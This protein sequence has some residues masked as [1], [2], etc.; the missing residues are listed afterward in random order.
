MVEREAE[1]SA[2]VWRAAV[3]KAQAGRVA[4]AMAVV[5]TVAEEWVGVV[6]VVAAV[7]MWAEMEVLEGGR[8][9][10]GYAAE[11]ARVEVAR[12]ELRAVV[13][14]AVAARAVDKRAVVVRDKVAAVKVA[15]VKVRVGVVRAAVGVVR[16]G[17]DKAAWWAVV[18]REAAGRW[19]VA[20]MAVVGLVGVGLEAAALAAV[21]RAVAARAREAEAAVAMVTAAKARADMALA[22]E[23]AVARV[24]VAAAV[25]VVAAAKE[26]AAHR[27][28]S[29]EPHTRT[30]DA[31]P[32]DSTSPDTRRRSRRSD[33]VHTLLGTHASTTCPSS[34]RS[35]KYRIDNMY[36]EESSSRCSPC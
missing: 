23:V 8:A 11:A 29:A 12:E 34:N 4:V 15:A 10:L 5:D 35:R 19:G 25:L 31:G 24:A 33:G 30:L 13:V 20:V 18:Q 14:T 9:D 32:N 27:H 36:P 1:A 21:V 22:V 28:K 26:A 6:M 2:A 17:E 3:V 7:A 16:A